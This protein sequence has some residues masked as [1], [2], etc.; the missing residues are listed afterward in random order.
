MITRLLSAALGAALLLAA[1][2]ASA[3]TNGG[4]EDATI[5]PLSGSTPG[6]L[7]NFTS[8][9]N[10]WNNNGLQVDITD[11]S[12]GTDPSPSTDPFLAGGSHMAHVVS[13]G[14]NDGLYQFD[15]FQSL[16]AD[17][18]VVSG[19]AQLGAYLYY[20][21]VGTVSTTATGVWQH[22]T[23]NIAGGANELVLYTFGGAA[24][25]YVDNV[26]S[27][28]YNPNLPAWSVTTATVPEPAT[29]AVMLLGLGLAGT[30]LRRRSRAAL[31]TS[32]CA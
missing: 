16:S 28:A 8:G 30:A 18:Y 25:F 20:S 31:A 7:G 2:P 24:E 9:W 27:G 17:F 22:L 21:G 26:V 10:G 3:V 1:A 23:L 19:A 14:L 32:P 15:S 11:A 12:P 13:A 29:W 6:G 5:T 4:F